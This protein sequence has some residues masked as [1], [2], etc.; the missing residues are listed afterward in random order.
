ML[1]VYLRI[2]HVDVVCGVVSRWPGCY[3]GVRHTIRPPEHASAVT[4]CVLG[5]GW[6]DGCGTQTHRVTYARDR[7]CMDV[8]GTHVRGEVHR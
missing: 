2:Q 5:V 6:V 7:V 3:V 1:G 4:A 8:G